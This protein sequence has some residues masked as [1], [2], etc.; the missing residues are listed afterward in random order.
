MSPES[1]PSA[2]RFEIELEIEAPRKVVWAA[3]SD[4]VQ[5]RRWF[6]PEASVT[7]GEGGEIVWG[8]GDAHGAWP[9]TIEVW[10]PGVR[11]RTRYESGIDDG[12]GGKLPL[13]LDFTLAGEGGHTTLR[14]V[15]SGFGPEA[16]FDQEY[17]GISRGWPVEL[18][19]LRLVLERHAG[20]DRQL[21]WAL[22]NVEGTLEE[23]WE[24]LTAPDGL[25]CGPRIDALS[26]GDPFR[27]ETADG[28][29]F[30]GTA[31]QCN[32]TA[33]SGVAET[34]DG[35]FLRLAVENCGGSHQAWL[36][37]A[38]YDRPE[39]E[40]TALRARFEALLARVFSEEPARSGGA[41]A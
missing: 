13:F 38:T 22:S 41:S 1:T 37:L 10:E 6:A 36:W 23:A 25:A 35:G 5:I 18:Q 8:W 9:Q 26:V 16:D 33:F 27:I 34:H 39:E 28:D 3:I 20:S 30:E 29:V 24:R 21:A 31:L 4:G 32:P 12:E 14:L 2:R 19:S 17:D 40:A 15:H 7:P 11:L